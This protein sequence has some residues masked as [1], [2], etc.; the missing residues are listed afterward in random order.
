M[1]NRECPYCH[2][3]VSLRRCLKYLLRGTAYTTTCNH[4]GRTLELEK[5]PLP[6]FYCVSAGFACGFIVM[7]YMLFM[8]HLT[9][10]HAILYFIP[11]GIVLLIVV[12]CL[13]LNRIY[14]K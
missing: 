14:F 4:C 11:I 6:F 3:K 9:F 10:G 1:G 5:E 13:T 8:K 7:Y 12:S 2:Q